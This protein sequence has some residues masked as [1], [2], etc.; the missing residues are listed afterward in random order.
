MAGLG[1]GRAVDV[2]AAQLVA[3]EAGMAVGL[4][5]PSDRSRVPLDVTTHFRALAAHDPAT[6]ALLLDALG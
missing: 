4:P 2:A 5:E 6:L 3:H 1:G